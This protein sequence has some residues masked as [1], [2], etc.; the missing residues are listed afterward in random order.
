MEGRRSGNARP[1]KDRV[2]PPPPSKKE[3]GYAEGCLA[4]NTLLST[5]NTPIAATSAVPSVGRT[6]AAL[7]IYT[8]SQSQQMFGGANEFM[9]WIKCRLS[10]RRSRALCQN[11]CV[12]TVLYANEGDDKA[13]DDA[14]KALFPPPSSLPPP[15][16]STHTHTTCSF[17]LSV[18]RTFFSEVSA[19][20]HNT[21]TAYS[22][23]SIVIRRRLQLPLLRTHCSRPE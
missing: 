6:A 9:L 21:A 14:S 11:N 7:L 23:I 19:G 22:H 15:L 2:P 3:R 10:S 17:A 13:A 18:H 8:S 1:S 20:N 16:P 5:E 4:N 12:C